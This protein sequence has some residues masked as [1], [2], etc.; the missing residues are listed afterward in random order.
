MTTEA[1]KKKKKDRR[2][3]YAKRKRERVFNKLAAFQEFQATIAPKMRRM[4]LDGVSAEDLLEEAAPLAAARIATIAM[5]ETDSSKALA[6]AKDI[7]DRAR[8]KAVERKQLEHKFERMDESSIDA[9]LIS[10]LK[11][12]SISETAL[13]EGEQ[14]QEGDENG[15]S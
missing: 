1:P 10:K 5:T 2:K 14:E 11:E 13:L 8:G 12:A 15:E 9:L 4:L 3:E 6:A 7:I